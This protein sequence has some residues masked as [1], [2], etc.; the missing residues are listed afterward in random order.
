MKKS[1]V[2]PIME[3]LAKNAGIK[4]VVEPRYGYV[5]QITTR[6]G[7]KRYMRNTSFDINPLGAAEI[8]KDKAYSYFFLS[9]M[10]YP[11]PEGDAFFSPRWSEAIG[12]GKDPE[13]AYRYALRLGFPVMVKPNSLSQGWGVTK[14]HNKR[15]FMQAVRAICKKDKVFLVQRVV[16]GHDYRVV[17]L[18]NQII[19]AYE[20]LPLSVT[21]DGRSTILGLLKQKQRQFEAVGRDTIINVDDQRIVNRLR[22][23]GFAKSSVLPKG[24]RVEL[25]DNRNLSTGGDALDVTDSMHPSFR[26]LCIKITRDMGLRYCGVDLM[27]DGELSSSVKKYAVLEVNAA[28]GLD[29]YASVGRRQRE[30]VDQMYLKVLMALAQ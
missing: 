13:A 22:R 27:V 16:S 7:R 8:A 26:K 12:I 19:S 21:G 2:T 24:K 4:I 25:L 6:R 17:V 29:H 23:Q 14:V 11:V 3:R 9:G 15:E 10:G 30:L 1:F 18:D 20:R 28:P 5:A